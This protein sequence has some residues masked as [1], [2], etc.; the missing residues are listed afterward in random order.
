MAVPL[1]VI[2]RSA[3]CRTIQPNAQALGVQLNVH[4]Q[5]F[6]Y[7]GFAQRSLQRPCPVHV[8]RPQ[9]S[10]DLRMPIRVRGKAPPD[11]GHRIDLFQQLSRQPFGILHA[12]EV[13]QILDVVVRRGVGAV[14]LVT[15]GADRRA[16]P[17]L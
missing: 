3:A 4:R 16:V 7:F 9:S 2:G 1:G 15:V 13:G 6:H 11:F 10:A 14:E 12:T 17:A 8:E 5:H